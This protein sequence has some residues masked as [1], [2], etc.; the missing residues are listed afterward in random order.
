L[1]KKLVAYDRTL[2][3]ADPRRMEPKKFGGAGARARRQKRWVQSVSPVFCLNECIFSVTGNWPLL[4]VCIIESY[5]FP[6]SFNVIHHAT[7]MLPCGEVD[8]SVYFCHRL[9]TVL[10]IK[11]CIRYIPCP[12]MLP[13]IPTAQC[14]VVCVL[15]LHNR[16]PQQR[17]AAC[18]CDE[19]GL[20]PWSLKSVATPQSETPR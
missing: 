4:Y 20:V 6:P 14:V 19:S 2:L 3:I 9:G 15:V 11:V 16:L 10:Y 1:K 7:S 18:A 5:I 13:S 17:T 12:R 8:R